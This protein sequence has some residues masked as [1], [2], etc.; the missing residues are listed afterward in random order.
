MAGGERRDF[1]KVQRNRTLRWIPPNWSLLRFY[2]KSV[3]QGAGHLCS[4]Q[5]HSFG[6]G[7]WEKCEVFTLFLTTGDKATVGEKY[8]EQPKVP[9]VQNTLALGVIAPLRNNTQTPIQSH[10]KKKIEY[11]TSESTM[12]SCPLRV[13][14]DV[15]RRRHEPRST[16]PS[17]SYAPRYVAHPPTRKSNTSIREPRME[18]L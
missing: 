14:I 6:F 11:F 5:R 8:T 2:T 13:L 9:Y 15:G 17:I 12:L 1:T 7:S 10:S 18:R 4:T 3:A 16:K